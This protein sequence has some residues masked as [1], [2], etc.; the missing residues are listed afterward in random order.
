MNKIRLCRKNDLPQVKN[1]VKDIWEGSDYLPLFFNKW[2]EDGNFYALEYRGKVAGTAKITMLPGK[3]AWLE[4]LRIDPALQG[5]G[6]G[7]ELSA[8]IFKKALN[9]KKQGLVRHLEF[10]TYYMNERSINISSEAG[11]ILQKAFYVMSRKRTK[12]IIE[13]RKFRFSRDDI[14]Y[15][16]YIPAG[17]KIIQNT[18]GAIKWLNEKGNAYEYQG[19]KVYIRE[20]DTVLNPA[21][22]N[23][24]P[25]IMIGFGDTFIDNEYY[26]IILPVGNSS[27]INKFKKKG[28]F[29]WDKPEKPNMFIFS[30]N[31]GVDID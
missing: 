21:V 1:F 13:P 3:V 30:Y 4:G 17:W 11:F 6:L 28:F 8:Y 10:C 27:I 22:R 16:E 18:R 19:Q 7:K 2:V 24:N 23:P 15:D 20:A 29:F 9:M 14:V 26:E 31:R 12:K 25:D 5:K